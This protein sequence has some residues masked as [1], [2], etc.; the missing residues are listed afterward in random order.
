M[1]TTLAPRSLTR[2]FAEAVWRVGPRDPGAEI[3]LPCPRSVEK[4]VEQRRFQ[5]LLLCA[6]AG[7]CGAA[8]RA[9]D[10]RVVAY[11]VLQRLQ[12][13][14]GLRMLLRSDHREVANSFFRYGMAPY[15]PGWEWESLRRQC[16]P[17]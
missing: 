1:R 11:A 3:S 4:S 16:R 8:G 7:G 17:I 15:S 6:F 9:R 2:P 5:T 14:L 12:R 10:L 13:D